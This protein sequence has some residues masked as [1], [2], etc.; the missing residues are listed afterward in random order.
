MIFSS[1]I[2]FS[3]SFAFAADVKTHATLPTSLVAWYDM[4]T[5]ND[6]TVAALNLTNNGT[7]P[8]VS[9]KINNGADFDGSDDY[10][11]RAGDHSY[12][13]GAYSY[14]A[15]IRVDAAPGNNARQRILMSGDSTSMNEISLDYFNDAGTLKAE[16]YRGKPGVGADFYLVNQTF[17]V[18]TFFHFVG[19]YDG[20]T[21]RMYV[22][23]S[24]IGTGLAASGSGNAATTEGFR[25]GADTGNGSLFNG[26]VDLVGVWTK[27]LSATEITDLYNSGNGIQYEVVAA[28]VVNRS[29]IIIIITQKIQNVFQ[30][31][32]SLVNPLIAFAK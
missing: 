17:T 31:F 7:T 20:T 32:A 12:A 3:V 18:G 16:F 1:G 28:P 8:F 2:F 23:G 22:N 14:S 5:V 21:L 6:S 15:W 9:A 29:V 30:M 25:I 4:E 26:V 24:E 13:G 27:A 11:S 19:T 10:F